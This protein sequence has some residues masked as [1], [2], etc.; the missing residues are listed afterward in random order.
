MTPAQDVRAPGRL[1]RLWRALWRPSARWSVAMLLVAGGIGVAA[2]VSGYSGFM[3][4]TNRLE[5]CTSCHSMATPFE[6]YR[7]SAHY[8][9]PS[10]VRVI[11]ADCHVP[12]EFVPK[13][14]RKVEAAKEVWH[15]FAGK[16]DTKEQFE[17]HRKELAERVWARM[18]ASDSRECRNCHSYPAMAFHKQ[19]PRGREK[20][21]EAMQKGTT[22]IECHKGVAHALPRRDD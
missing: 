19:S 7:K 17:E 16:L 22:C 6:E 1:G 8:T 5:F 13:M 2:A 18:T 11:C 9:N 21:E 10:G 4:Y 3:A 20:M 14:I 15:H 12:R